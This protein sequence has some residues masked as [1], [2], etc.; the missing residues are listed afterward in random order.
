MGDASIIAA[1]PGEG[2]GVAGDVG[3]RGVADYGQSVKIKAIA[4]VIRPAHLGSSGLVLPGATATTDPL[5]CVGTFAHAWQ[6]DGA[7]QRGF[8]PVIAIINGPAI[9]AGAG[10]NRLEGDVEGIIGWSGRDSRHF[11]GRHRRIHC[12]SDRE[13]FRFVRIVTERMSRQHRN[14]DRTRQAVQVDGLG[15]R[16]FIAPSTPIETVSIKFGELAADAQRCGGPRGWGGRDAGQA[17]PGLHPLI[18]PERPIG[19][20][21][22]GGNHRGNRRAAGARTQ[23]VGRENMRFAQSK[24]QRWSGP[25]HDDSGRM[26]G[27]NVAGQIG[28]IIIDGVGARLVEGERQ[29]RTIGSAINPIDDGYR[30]GVLRSKVK[31][32][33]GRGVVHPCDLGYIAGEAQAGDR[34]RHVQLARLIGDRIRVALAVLDTVENIEVREF[35]VVAAAVADVRPS[36]ARMQHLAVGPGDLADSKARL[37]RIVEAHVPP[38]F[39]VGVKSHRHVVGRNR[40]GHCRIGQIVD[41]QGGAIALEQSVWNH[42]G[43]IVGIGEEIENAVAAG[44]VVHDLGGDEVGIDGF[45]DGSVA[46]T[47]FIGMGEGCLEVDKLAGQRGDHVPGP[48]AGF[49]GID[50]AQVH[51]QRRFIERGILNPRT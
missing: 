4:G 10:I 34:R 24:C 40:T 50:V 30:A 2:E 18:D 12:P 11:Q 14:G 39:A 47:E 21:G 51:L 29:R 35:L 38:A 26:H 42:L 27:F 32:G 5:H 19:G 31:L 25:R 43:V 46:A 9:K 36:I 15:N 33:R 44:F 48:L 1:V 45:D 49:A 8:G 17:R 41:R 37:C 20:Q 16:S 7:A 28:R 23:Q 22:G 3:K 6:I 13:S